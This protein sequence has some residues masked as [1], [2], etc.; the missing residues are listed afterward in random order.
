MCIRQALMSNSEKNVLFYCRYLKAVLAPYVKKVREAYK[1][2]NMLAFVSSDGEQSQIDTFMESESVAVLN[3]A[4][5]LEAKHA[6]SFSARGNA[7][8]AGNY[9]K[10]SKTRVRHTTKEKV[11]VSTSDLRRVLDTV[12][13]SLTHLSAAKRKSYVD[14]VCRVV[15]CAQATLTHSIIVTGFRKTGQWD[16]HSFNFDLR[17]QCSTYQYT[18]EQLAV[19]T[20][21]THTQHN[22]KHSARHRGHVCCLCVCW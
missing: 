7:L 11:E 10:A 13:A 21:Y 18:A 3:D 16:G 5:I 4:L 22:H 15:A 19:Y 20:H 17:M 14:G 9:F 2:S 1:L 12:F 8:D 6:A